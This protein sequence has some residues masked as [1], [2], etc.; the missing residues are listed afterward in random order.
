MTSRSQ[1]HTINFYRATV[2]N[3]S[4]ISRGKEARK[5]EKKKCQRRKV[6]M[7]TARSNN[8]LSLTVTVPY[9]PYGDVRSSTPKRSGVKVPLSSKSASLVSSGTLWYL[10]LLSIIVVPSYFSLYPHSQ[11]C[12]V[13]RSAQV[14]MVSRNRRRIL[15]KT[16]PSTD[17]IYP[18]LT[19]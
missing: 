7:S 1:L 16:K 11:L 6:K 10:V 4:M 3:K 18:T 9:I 2:K 17:R 15:C 8:F 19:R 13:N 14:V 12:K 5:E